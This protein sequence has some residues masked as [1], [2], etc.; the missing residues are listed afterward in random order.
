MKRN[1]KGQFV[2]SRKPKRNP[3]TFKGPKKDEPKKLTAK[4]KAKQYDQRWLFGD[5]RGIGGFEQH[6]LFDTRKNP[7]IRHL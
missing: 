4:Q 7:R 6:K 2:G 5:P 1:A 3:P